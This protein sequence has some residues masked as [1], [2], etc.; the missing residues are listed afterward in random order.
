MVK[1]SDDVV[2]LQWMGVSTK[3]CMCCCAVS[4]RPYPSVRGYSEYLY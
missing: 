2:S 3:A 4:S 1:E